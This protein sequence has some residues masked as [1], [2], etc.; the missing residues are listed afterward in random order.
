MAILK[1]HQL[2]T[3]QQQIS[4]KLPVKTQ[5]ESLAACLDSLL[6]NQLALKLTIT[7]MMYNNNALLES[8][9]NAIEDEEF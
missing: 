1:W 5:W 4:L 9:N 7:K 8:I 6:Q 2:T 3:Y